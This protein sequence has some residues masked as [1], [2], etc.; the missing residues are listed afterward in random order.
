MPTPIVMPQMGESIAEGTIV[1]WI[2]KVGDH[3]D[4]D[5]PLFEI[6]T[7]KVDAEIPSPSEGVLTE[8]LAREGDTV[9]VDS[10]V[11]TIQVIGEQAAQGAPHVKTEPPDAHASA[12][13]P[14]APPVAVARDSVVVS[15]EATAGGSRQ[16]RS[17][18]LVR[19]IARE[20]N[21]DV[22]RI[23]GSGLGGRVTK[24][25]ILAFL[26][27][28]GRNRENGDP[29]PVRDSDERVEVQPLS[30]MRKKIAEHMVLS[31]QTSAH[32]HT[33]FHVGFSDIERIRSAK[34][35]EYERLGV[36]LSY[37]AFIARA[38]I[39]ALRRHPIVNASL[40]GDRIVYKQDVHLG[41]AVA[42]ETG[43]IVPVIKNAGE[44]NL[45]GLS[46]AIADVAARARAKQ[47]TP[48][49]VHGGTFT[50]TNP[51]QLGAQFGMPIINQPQVAIL[52]VG[53]VEKRPVVVDDGLTIRT[54]AYLTLGYDHRLIDGAVADQFMADVKRNIEQFE[55]NRI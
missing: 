27:A 15:R 19:R 39:D 48:D 37:M 8:I 22:A 38:V 31:K 4:R 44:K 2:K 12:P 6:S 36:K 7:D 29:R 52:G 24:K 50:I 20:H 32:V 21:V 34:K 3:V 10:V 53:T 33:V 54:M 9:S 5:E 42:L 49:E 1:R 25:D 30:A 43:L 35:A 17:S 51:G 47:L 28:G 26:A 14:V 46:R 40:D 41:I 55:Q 13:A 23:T 11:G 45:L 18:P 16:Q